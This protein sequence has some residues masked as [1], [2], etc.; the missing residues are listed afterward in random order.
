[1]I[2]FLLKDIIVRLTMNWM[3]I[4]GTIIIILV[5]AFRGGVMGAFHAYLSPRLK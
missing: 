5:L 1:V 3:L 4:L 2:Y